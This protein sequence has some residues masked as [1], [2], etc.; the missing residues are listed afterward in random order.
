MSKQK[1]LIR[2]KNEEE[3]FKFWSGA[4]SIDFIDKATTLKG[5]FPELK[6]NWIV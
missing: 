1:K 5:S 2:F 3:E 4:N 6:P